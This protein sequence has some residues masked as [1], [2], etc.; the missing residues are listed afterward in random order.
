MAGMVPERPD[1]VGPVPH[2]FDEVVDWFEHVS[3]ALVLLAEFPLSE[4][5]RATREFE[6]RVRGHLEEFGRKL[7]Q[8]RP[9]PGVAADARALLRADHAWFGTSIDQLDWFYRIVANEDHGGHR[10]ALGQYGRVFT[11]A[12]RRHRAE[13]R[14]YLGGAGAGAGRRSRRAP[15]RQP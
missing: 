2:E 7:D 13:E 15:P 1:A 12:L 5:E 3:T 11:E 14:A 8:T 6:R 9:S 4:V 10:Q